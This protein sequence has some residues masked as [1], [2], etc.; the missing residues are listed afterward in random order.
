MFAKATTFFFVFIS[1]SPR[2]CPNAKWSLATNHFIVFLIHCWSS[3]PDPLVNVL[4]LLFVQGWV[5]VIWG[6][7]PKY[8]NP[9]SVSLLLISWL[10]Y[11]SGLGWKLIADDVKLL[12]FLHLPVP[13]SVP[14]VNHSCIK[15]ETLELTSISSFLMNV[16]WWKRKVQK[17]NCCSCYMLFRNISI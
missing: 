17:R 2:L 16:H 11:C 13:Q 12:A 4:F 3:T 5:T 1:L 10:T 14:P 9:Y 6:V 15:V 7:G 8:K